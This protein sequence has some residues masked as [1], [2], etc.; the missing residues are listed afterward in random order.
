MQDIVLAI[1]RDDE[2]IMM[3][4]NSSQIAPLVG[5]WSGWDSRVVNQLERLGQLRWLVGWEDVRVVMAPNS[6]LITCGWGG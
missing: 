6:S 4:P 3:A 1:L 5:G 2:C